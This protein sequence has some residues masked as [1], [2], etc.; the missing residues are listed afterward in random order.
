LWGRGCRKLRNTELRIANVPTQI[1]IVAA[2]PHFEGKE[3]IIH[4]AQK[5]CEVLRNVTDE[6][7]GARDSSVKTY[8][9]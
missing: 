4:Q 1:G 3:S 9:K 8:R 7:A 2:M 6:Q 5:M